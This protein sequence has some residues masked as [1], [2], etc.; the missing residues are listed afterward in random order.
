MLRKHASKSFIQR[1]R[2][3]REW[4]RMQ[5]QGSVMWRRPDMGPEL[6]LAERIPHSANFSI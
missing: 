1:Q 2:K 6:S 3:F 4:G 5:T